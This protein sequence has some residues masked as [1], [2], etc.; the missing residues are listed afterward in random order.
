[1]MPSL[2]L[3]IMLCHLLSVGWLSWISILFGLWLFTLTLHN[4]VL[5]SP[6]C[7]LSTLFL[8]SHALSFLQSFLQ[9]IIFVYHFVWLNVQKYWSFRFF[10]VAI[11]D[12]LEVV[13]SRTSSLLLCAV[14]DILIILLG[15]HIS[16]TSSLF[17][18]AF[19]N[20]HVSEPIE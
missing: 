16:N 6:W 9:V 5:S 15:I 18:I 12:L 11:S 20:V 7:Y 3:I 1:M 13:I 14:H 19:V 8:V 10:I 4:L 2:P 17:W